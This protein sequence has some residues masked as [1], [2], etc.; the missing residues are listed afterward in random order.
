MIIGDCKYLQINIGIY[1]I[2][3]I[4]IKHNYELIN[5]ITILNHT[6]RFHLSLVVLNIK[7]PFPV[8]TF[9]P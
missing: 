3:S 7:T 4:I 1:V 2:L 9:N 6:Q 5:N 8:R